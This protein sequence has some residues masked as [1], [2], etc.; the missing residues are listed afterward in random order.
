MPD[1]SAGFNVSVASEKC[2]SSFNCK[3]RRENFPYGFIYV[4]QKPYISSFLV[5][6]LREMI[7]HVFP[8]AGREIFWAF[9]R[10]K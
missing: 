3:T 6:F 4:D 5:L 9:G 2:Y 10:V 8:D 7:L 1:L